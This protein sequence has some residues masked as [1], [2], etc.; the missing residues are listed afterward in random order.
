MIV[1]WTILLLPAFLVLISTTFRFDRKLENLL[2]VLFGLVLILLIGYRHEVGGDWARYLE[3]VFMDSRSSNIDFFDFTGGGDYAYK[4]IFWFS[5]HYLDGIYSTNLICAIFFVSG[6]IRFCRSMPIPWLALLIATPFL[7]IVVSM[8]YTRQSASVGFLLWALV[9]LM[10][11]KVVSFY[12]AII[13][14]SLFHFILLLMLPLGLIYTPKRFIL[15][16]SP[17]FLL[18]VIE[19]VSLF[20]LRIEHMIYYYVTIK[21]H[22][23]DGAVIRVFISFA[24]SILFFTYRKKFKYIY[25]DYSLWFV[26]SIVNVF[27][28]LAVF[29]YSTLID[30]IAIYFLPIQLVVLSRIPTLITSR[31]NRTIFILGVIIMYISVLFVWLYFGNHSNKWL[32]YQNLIFL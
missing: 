3:Q 28:F 10:S 2:L 14:G 16:L 11:K 6:L 4:V 31:Y 25:R 30:R 5:L 24:S 9:D 1:Y 29:S 32:P 19:I 8:G 13:I 7:I 23:S 12:I 18:V 26:F 22:H 27:L 15:A 17:I 21:F 20:Y